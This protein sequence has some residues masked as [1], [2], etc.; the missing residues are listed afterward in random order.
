M[1]THISWTD[2]TWNPTTGC[3]KVSAGCKTLGRV[4]ASNGYVLIR[5]GKDHHLADVRGYAYEH[6]LVAERMLGRPLKP[7][8]QVHHRNEVKHDNRPENLEV[9][10]NRAHHA[11]KHRSPNSGNRLPGEDNPII[12]CACG[13]GSQLEKFDRWG[14]P[15]SFK[16]G[17]N[18]HR[19]SA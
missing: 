2:E 4:V 7:G 5:V 13:C 16:S 1:T 18:V 12:A 19:R 8:E 3:S 17:H 15:R 6:R 9:V 11:V 10:R 14:R